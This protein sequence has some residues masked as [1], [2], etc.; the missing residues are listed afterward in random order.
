MIPKASNFFFDMV[1]IASLQD[2]D[3][4][5][6]KGDH[7]VRI[8]ACL[9]HTK[10][11]RPDLTKKTPPC[12]YS[13]GEIDTRFTYCAVSALSLLGRLEAIH[14]PKAIDFVQAC[15]NFDGGYGSMPGAESHA[16]QSNVFGFFVKKNFYHSF[17][18]LL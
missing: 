14:V 5:A 18:S 8:Y 2:Q 1:D 9:Q 4:G 11:I 17:I 3:T 12:N 15:K 10:S 7:W 6:F 16:G 13:K